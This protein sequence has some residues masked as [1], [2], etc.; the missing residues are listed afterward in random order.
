[1]QL[2]RTHRGFTLT[3]M[4][5][6]IAIITLLIGGAMATLSSIIETRNNEE[7]TRRLN[8]AVDALIGY[9]VVNKRLPCPAVCTDPPTCSAGGVEAPAGGGAACTNPYGGFLPGRTIGFTPVDSSGYG[10][11]PW[12]NKIRYAVAQ[13]VDTTGG[14]CPAA[15]HFTTAANLKSNGVGCKPND[16]DILCSTVAAGVSATCN[17]TIRVA[18]QNTIVFI[19]FS[20]GKN[21]AIAAGQGA[22]DTAN[23][24]GNASFVHRFQSTT[25]STL[26][27]YDDVMVIVPAG[28]FYQKLIAAGVLP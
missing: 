28:V 7:A 15:Q 19:V 9:A 25:D 8:A 12:G 20:T 13:T 11:D 21:G 26:G 23:T 27:V 4:A 24:D 3:E 17:S 22:D 5:V 2:S 1:M 10:T 18:D 14:V 6:V 16:L